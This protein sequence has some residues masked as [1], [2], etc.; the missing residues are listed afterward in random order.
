M[1]DAKRAMRRRIRDT[2]AEMDASMLVRA[3]HELRDVALGAPELRAAR[4]VAAYVS[5][6][7]EPGTGPLVEALHDRGTEVLLPLVLPDLD[8]DW[9]PYTGAAGLV[10]APR[11]LLEP[12]A[13]PVGIEAVT[14]A[15]AI[16][17]PGLAADRRGTR[18]GQGGG[19]Y[20]RVLARVA[21]RVFSCVVLH[22]GE[23]IDMPLPR[24]VHDVPVHAA[25]TPSG[26]HRFKPSP[27]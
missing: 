23:L 6:G 21:G 19:C 10:S 7:S 2:R 15:D 27:E 24:D 9:A 25:A 26:L 13:D 4:V 3:A 16:L 8:L 12:V 5:V 11:G 20:D 22:D 17:V 14:S 18:L 1:A